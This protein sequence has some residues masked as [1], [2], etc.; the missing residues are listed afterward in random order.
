MS[1]ITSGAA[2]RRES[3]R[4]HGTK[5]G[6]F[7]YQAHSAPDESAFDAGPNWGEVTIA[8]G[9]E[10]PW[11][12]VQDVVHHDVGIAEVGTASHGGIKLSPQRNRA[13]PEQW[14]QDGGW[15]EEDGDH[16]L[17]RARFPESFVQGDES[18]DDLR[19]Q[20]E[21]RIRNWFPDE[22]EAVT[23]E[24]LQPGQSTGRDAELERK[25]NVDNFVTHGAWAAEDGMVRVIARRASTGEERQFLM[26]KAEYD[27]RTGL[28]Y[29][30]T[31]P[32]AF[33]E[34][35]VADAPPS[36]APPASACTFDTWN[37]TPGAKTRAERELAKL[38]RD[39]DGTVSTFEEYLRR[40]EVHGKTAMVGDDGR[41]TYY[42]TLPNSRVAPVSKAVWD[43]SLAPSELTPEREAANRLHVA[44]AKL[45]K[46]ERAQNRAPFGRTTTAEQEQL[47]QARQ[48]RD[49]YQV[50]ASAAREA[51]NEVRRSERESINAHV[52]RS[53][54][55]AELA[56]TMARLER[57]ADGRVSPDSD[58]GA[59]HR[60]QLLTEHGE[61]NGYLRTPPTTEGR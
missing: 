58:P 31:D 60:F 7:G 9:D 15:Y 35:S 55:A 43:A 37:C 25:A 26:P 27:T 56:A 5:P 49:G 8:E 28:S 30:I 41:T 20:A 14:R 40:S 36:L 22:W 13:I 2:A 38:V 29:N 24:T 42:L 1:H 3:A 48:T 53:T 46:L 21:E 12:E 44:Q 34:Y 54:Y 18:P 17:V 51:A 6:E 11:G 33:E 50:A 19:E 61:A 57:T 52:T 47:R 4:G 45:D 23:G 59:L 39:E 32:S 16:Y 10:S